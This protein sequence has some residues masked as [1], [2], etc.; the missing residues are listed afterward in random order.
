MQIRGGS[1]P[2]LKKLGSGL[3]EPVERLLTKGEVCRQPM[4]RQDRPSLE[5]AG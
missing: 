1:L 4:Q 5:K 2:L 3:L